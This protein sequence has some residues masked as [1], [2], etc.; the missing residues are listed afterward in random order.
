MG[1]ITAMMPLDISVKLRI[2]ENFHIGVSY[3]PSEINIYTQLFK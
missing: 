1:N 2:I 3:S